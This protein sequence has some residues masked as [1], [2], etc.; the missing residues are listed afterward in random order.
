MKND[1]ID[2]SMWDKIDPLIECMTFESILSKRDRS[3]Y[4]EEIDPL[5]WILILP[6]YLILPLDRSHVYYKIDPL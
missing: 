4:M 3:P 5:C 2:L 6:E 1:Q